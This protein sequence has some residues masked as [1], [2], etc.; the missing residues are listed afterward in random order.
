M[1]ATGLFAGFVLLRAEL[2]RRR[3]AANPYA[4]IVIIGVTGFITSKL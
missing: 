1:L 3:I 2:F 4:I